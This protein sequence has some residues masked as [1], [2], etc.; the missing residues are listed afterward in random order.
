LG[1]VACGSDEVVAQMPACDS[2][3]VL[4]L[5]TEI[6]KEEAKSQLFFAMLKKAGK[7]AEDLPYKKAVELRGRSEEL[8]KVID[9]VDE[10]VEK[11]NMK[12]Y[13]INMDNQDTAEKKVWCKADMKAEKGTKMAINYIA[14]FV[15][16]DVEVEVVF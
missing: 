6:L 9:I 3:D 10:A 5:T 2:Q 7:P 11:K 13:D 4:E 1:L 14:Q 15:G 12:Y 16:D 8:G